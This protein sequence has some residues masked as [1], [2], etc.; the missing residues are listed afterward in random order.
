MGD[1]WHRIAR[2]AFI[3]AKRKLRWRV[4][5]RTDLREFDY[6]ALHGHKHILMVW[7]HEAS[8]I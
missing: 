2:S 1:R 7:A 3:D 4:I 5:V 8:L 6:K